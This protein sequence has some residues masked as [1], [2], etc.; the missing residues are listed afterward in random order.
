MHQDLCSSR[1]RFCNEFAFF[2]HLLHP[3]TEHIVLAAERGRHLPR[4]HERKTTPSR[5]DSVTHA[6]N[7][8]AVTMIGSPTS[9]TA[10]QP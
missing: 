5:R 10:V 8:P 1:L 6:S 3:P 9:F 2:G 4:P 7:P